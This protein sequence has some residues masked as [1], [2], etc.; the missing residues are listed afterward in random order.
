MASMK[1]GED[2]NGHEF[3]IVAKDEADAQKIME[4]L[5]Q[6]GLTKFSYYPDSKSFVISATVDD[7]A[8]YEKIANFI[9]EKNKTNETHERRIKGESIL[10]SDYGRIIQEAR[11]AG[12][13]KSGSDGD[14]LLTHAETR[15]R[16]LSGDYAALS[17][18]KRKEFSEKVREYI[19]K[20]KKK[21][22]LSD[23]KETP[24]PKVD[25]KEAKR[26]AAPALYA[27]GVPKEPRSSCRNENLLMGFGLYKVNQDY[28]SIQ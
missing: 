15:L 18:A 9:N 27:V 7:L 6:E 13:F 24:K 11:D 25:L 16:R 22:G 26:R 14:K 3:E 17:E 5:K 1:E 2:Y 4:E 23:Y 20:F 10:S 28:G 19:A 12:L 8:N 21:Y